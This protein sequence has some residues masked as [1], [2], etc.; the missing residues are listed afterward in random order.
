MGG[1][2]LQLV[3]F[4]GQDIYLTGN[5]E[6]SYFKSVYRRHTNFSMECIKQTHN[7]TISQNAFKLNYTINRSGDLLSNMYLEIDMP[8]Q[9]AAAAP[10][11]GL[12]WCNYSN[13]TAYSYIK[14]I[15][16]L[17]GEKVIDKQD[18]KWLDIMNQLN[19]TNNSGLDYIVNNHSTHDTTIKTPKPIKL[20]VPLLFWFCKDVSQSLP[21]IAL[22]YHEVKINISFRSLRNIIN[23][24]EGV[25]A[26]TN[27]LKEPGIKLWGNYILLDKD[28]RRRFSQETHEYL[29]EQI[30]VLRKPYQN[31]I[32]ISLN[33]P[34]KSLYW[35]IQ[36][37]NSNKEIND[38][39]K[40]NHT[41][42]TSNDVEWENGNDYLNYDIHETVNKSYIKTIEEYEHF[43]EA[44][45]LFN[46]IERFE[47]QDATYFR[48]L[49]PLVSDNTFP[50]KHIYMYSFCLKPE[51]H[52]PTGSCNFSRIDN[53]TFSFTGD[54]SYNN[55]T[56]NLYA[57]NY[58]ILRI[59]EG[60][61]GLLYSN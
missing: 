9:P 41:A 33:H 58:N 25:T 18:G 46:G 36:N 42:N 10:Q 29:I 60:M 24:S 34:V 21:L 38:Y 55:Y 43:R 17:I 5:P 7:G 20:F 1:G 51:E 56:F 14:D 32:H 8:L 50:A 27:S 57:R 16:L 11:A 2:T 53:V 47:P 19:H 52:K 4:G 48:T 30:Q 31:N 15:E 49:Q 39:V 45:I 28:E 6:F 37:N 23:M 22:Q 59:M 35:V 54:Q 26:P 12:D 44:T 61:G 13:N 40:I 3:I